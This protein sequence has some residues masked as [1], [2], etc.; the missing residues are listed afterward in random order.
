MARV[1]N[2]FDRS[3]KILNLVVG[4]IG[5]LVAF[6][7][8]ATAFNIIEYREWNKIRKEAQDQLEEAKKHLA[9]IKEYQNIA[10]GELLNF[11]EKLKQRLDTI[12]EE[13][14][15]SEEDKKKYD[16]Y[17]Q[18]YKIFKMLGLPL[19]PEDFLNY[20]YALFI[21]GFHE[22][23][24]EAFNKAI[25]EYPDYSNAY[26]Y[27]GLALRLIGKYEEALKDFNKAIEVSPRLAHPW[28]Y[29]GNMLYELKMYDDALDA[30]NKA[31]ELHPSYAEA[32]LDKSALLGELG[33]YKE[34]IEF[35]DKAIELK[36][37]SYQAFSNKGAALE[38]LGQYD[39]ALKSFNK[40]IALNPNNAIL[41]FN[42]SLT[43]AKHG[44]RNEAFTDLKK[45][46]ELDKSIKEI[47]K[48]KGT[49]KN[50]WKEEDFK[51]L[52]E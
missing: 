10:E 51:K 39:E 42:R 37:D 22:E 19:D 7:I 31:I 12:T 30:Y 28:K 32:F 36:P 47:A 26:T 46:I 1:K 20:A 13:N 45:A 34:S 14:K 29:K 33:R 41:F 24:L 35:A 40:A 5:V 52:V 17:R 3:I 44:K 48:K 18:A 23:A 49:F 8:L 25:A 38:E 2:D 21:N 43:Y 9:S 11:R 4:L 50:F 6:I 15:I 27:R 16:E